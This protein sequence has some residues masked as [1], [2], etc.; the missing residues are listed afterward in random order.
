MSTRE[1][2]QT[3]DLD[4]TPVWTCGVFVIRQLH[5]GGGHWGA[6]HTDTV[7]QTYTEDGGGAYLCSEHECWAD[8]RWLSLEAAMRAAIPAEVK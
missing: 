7:G 8:G 1:W 6:N 2:Q 4:G 3:Q 5:S